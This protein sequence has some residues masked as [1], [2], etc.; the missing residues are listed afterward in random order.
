MDPTLAA[1]FARQKEKLER[2]EDVAEIG[3]KADQKKQLDPV[4]A[5]RWEKLQAGKC[6]E[7]VVN[8]EIGS[9]ADKTVKLDPVLAKRWSKQQER[10]ETGVCDIPDVVSVADKSTKLDPVLAERWAAAHERMLTG[11]SDVPEVGSRADFSRKDTEFS[12]TFAK[13]Q[14]QAKQGTS[15]AERCHLQL[16]AGQKTE[17]TVPWESS[18]Q[19]GR[20]QWSAVALSDL[21]IDLEV[22]AVVRPPSA[23]EGEVSEVILQRHARG[24]TFVGSLDAASDRRL[25]VQG[26]KKMRKEVVSVIFKFSNS[27]SW[28]TGKEVELVLLKD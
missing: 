22:C 1:R 5:Q 9:I 14:K 18:G 10:Y 11:N 15:E 8:D 20:L 16:S 4:L 6:L 12:K 24:G 3:S 23:A 13:V 2:G 17:H 21:T 7:T 25:A 26:D 28:F 19:S 27:F